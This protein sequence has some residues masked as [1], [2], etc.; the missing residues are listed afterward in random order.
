MSFIGSALADAGGKLLIDAGSF[1]LEVPSDLVSQARP[2]AGRR[3]V[4]GVRPED[5]A[6]RAMAN[7]AQPAW[8]IKATVDVHEPLG[9]DSIFNLS[10][11]PNPTFADCDAP[12]RAG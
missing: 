3:V 11:G 9:S 6:D 1:R 7:G 4:F 10:P 5:I 12:R 8:T 2:W